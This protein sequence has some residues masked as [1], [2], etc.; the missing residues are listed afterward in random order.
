VRPCLK[1]NKGWRYSSVI[2]GLPGTFK[3]LGSIPSTA[4]KKKKKLEN[5]KRIIEKNSA[6]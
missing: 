5:I 3:A 4:K 2:K 6:S 1:K